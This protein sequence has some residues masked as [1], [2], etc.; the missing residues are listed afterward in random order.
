MKG[1]VWYKCDLHLH[2]PASNCYKDK[3]VSAEEWALECKRKGLDCIAITDHNTGDF[4]DEYKAACEKIGI[5]VFP[6]VE[7]TYGSSGTHLLILFPT[8][9]TTSTV[10]EFLVRMNINEQSRAS[11]ETISDSNFEKIKDEAKKYNALVIPA[12]IDEFSG[13]GE[14]KPSAAIKILQDIDIPAVQ[15]VNMKLYQN[16]NKRVASKELQSLSNELTSIYGTNISPE[17]TESWIKIIKNAI[18][19]GKCILTFSDNPEAEGKSEH[20][21]WGIGS[22]YTWIKMSMKPTIQSLKEALYFSKE[23]II[24]DFEDIKEILYPDLFIDKL[25]VKN[26]KLTN[27]NVEIDFSP[28]STTIIG[29][30]GTGKSCIIR[31]LLYALGK[32]EEFADFEEIQKELL[33]FFHKS[34]GVLSNTAEVSLQLSHN[35][36]TYI[37][38]RTPD[39]HK[40]FF[41]SNEGNRKE[42][43]EQLIKYFSSKINIYPQKQ[44]FEISSKQESIREILDSYNQE[45]I[46]QIKRGVNEKLNDYQLLV[47]EIH[48][49]KDEILPEGK[50]ETEKQQVEQR[51]KKMSASNI[52]SAYSSNKDFINLSSKISNDIDEITEV[53]VE[54]KRNISELHVTDA[55]FGIPE[56]DTMRTSLQEKINNYKQE[57]FT[58]IENIDKEIEKYKTSLASSHWSEDATVAKLKYD[59]I[60]EGL[61]AEERDVIGN[62]GKVSEKI[63]DIE[64]SLKII[65][66]KKEILSSKQN[67]LN[68]LKTHYSCAQD[69]LFEERNDFINK[70]FSNMDGIKIK[71]N[72]QTDFDSYV[73]KFRVICQKEAT[74]QASFEEMQTKLKHREIKVSD[75]QE[76]IFLDSSEMNENIFK[77]TRLRSSL[78]ALSEEQKV[79]L[80][81]LTPPDKVDIKLDVNEE[82]KN[83]SLSN[84][85]AGQKTSAILAMILAHGEYP[86]ILDQPEDDLDSQLINS[87]IVEGIKREKRKRQIITVTHNAN[88]PVNGDSEWM[89]CME[90]ARN[91]GVKIEGS[92]DDIGIKAEICNIMEGGTKA[93]KNRARRY[94]FSDDN[95]LPI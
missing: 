57:I 15:V 89:V 81:L 63:Q 26:T 50:L 49:I 71:V 5:V 62:I 7:L 23:R 93:F 32:E 88:I 29:G 22:R 12:H 21:L 3:K 61:S 75:I 45:K 16:C 2:T 34:D 42:E 18:D 30:R 44:V 41:V 33:S 47:K 86:L 79:N 92:V 66:A 35:G 82:R 74:F 17:K 24:N 55:K 94:G 51:L 70:N 28:E 1:N 64:K 46:E 40:I 8:D 68:E 83:V 67:K 78:Q 53:P 38:E 90:S 31:F 85:S 39:S 19:K 80:F 52:Q 91:I 87:L 10:N 77:E 56:I 54:L 25:I 37:I 43:N 48:A 11:S 59:E 95:L 4:V 65:E 84:A 58:T 76:Q 9:S 73:T 13:L 69:K 6:G 14:Q 36:D 20:G 60:Y 72:K 27:S